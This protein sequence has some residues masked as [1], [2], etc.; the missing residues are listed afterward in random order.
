MIFIVLW[1]A[2][3][4]FLAIYLGRSP[5]IKSWLKVLWK[6]RRWKRWLVAFLV[7]VI[8]ITVAY[9]RQPAAE[10]TI[11]DTQ[12]I[13][14]KYS[15]SAILKLD[16]I[17]KI[18]V[19]S[20]CNLVTPKPEIVYVLP[21]IINAY[22][23]IVNKATMPV[24]TRMD[25]TLV[26]EMR[27][28]KQFKNRAILL[29][30]LLKKKLGNRYSIYIDVGENSVHTLR[31]AYT[32]EPW[33]IEQLCALP[34]LEI[35]KTNKVDPALLMALIKH[36]SNFDFDY[37][38]AKDR[39]GLLLLKE[40]EGI[41]QVTLAAQRLQKQMEVGISR[42][43]AIATFYPDYGIGDKPENWKHSPLAKNW[44]DQVLADV[45]YYRENGLYIN[46]K[47]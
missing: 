16:S 12:D 27:G 30:K 42:E 26:I 17:Q 37:K 18:R 39:R 10:E 44:V 9:I 1:I 2:I 3:L 31:V 47:E 36:I 19:D 15:A 6:A 21:M 22:N 38:G 45:T 24:L 13:F 29:T 40:G 32:G 20:T 7:I 35:A 41:E 8:A 4:A 46:Y 23:E 5:K 33:D 14:H 11:T 43:N 25:D 28:Y 34:I